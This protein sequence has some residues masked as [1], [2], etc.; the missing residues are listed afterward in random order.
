MY[1]DER[2]A[3]AMICSESGVMYQLVS[4]YPCHF[5]ELAF[6][7]DGLFSKPETKWSPYVLAVE[8]LKVC[9]IVQLVGNCHIMNPAAVL[10]FYFRY[11]GDTW[12]AGLQGH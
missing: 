5:D 11:S 7:L 10:K 4:R 1:E 9:S 3:T 2:P 8:R 6:Q 12:T